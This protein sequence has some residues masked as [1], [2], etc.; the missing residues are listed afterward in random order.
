MPNY[1]LAYHGGTAPETAEEGAEVMERWGAWF[2]SMG[3]AVV[4]G[5]NPVGPSRTVDAK[6][7]ADH[8]GAN[9]LS[10]YSIIHAADFDAALALAAGCPIIGEGSVEVAE[11]IPM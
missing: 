4:D 1:I 10:G 11:I 3:D 9:P 2:A 7:V 8:G 5:G 6:G